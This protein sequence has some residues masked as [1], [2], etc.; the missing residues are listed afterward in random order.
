MYLGMSTIR[1]QK[2]I[3]GIHRFKLPDS[4]LAAP[5]GKMTPSASPFAP[6]CLLQGWR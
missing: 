4:N 1:I 5:D 3:V 2:L 6:W